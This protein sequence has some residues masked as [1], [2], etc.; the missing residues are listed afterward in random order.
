MYDSQRDAAIRQVSDKEEFIIVECPRDAMQGLKE[1]IDTKRKI[2]Y[3]NSLL[4]VNFHTLDFGSFVSPKAIPQMRDTAE[5]LKGLDL[6]N[7]KTKLLVIVANE[8]GGEQACQYPQISYL[9]Y[10]F[11]VSEEFQKRNTNKSIDESLKLVEELY[12]MSKSVG[13]E[14][15]VY[16]SMGFGNPYGEEWSPEIV[17]KWSKVLADMG[18]R[19]L[20][21]SDTV[22]MATVDSIRHIFE[23]LIPSLPH[24]TFGA[25]LHTLPYQ[26]FEKIDAAYKAGCR[27]FDGAIRGFGGCPMAKDE[28]TGNMPTEKLISYML[29]EQLPNSLNLLAF[30]SAYNEALKIFN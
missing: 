20:S 21:V 12:K 14:L 15:V 26:W 1:F 23:L 7:T 28:L 25:H 4:K 11:S 10:P 9:G 6:S 22:G 16:L 5:V 19:T 17:L 30:E 13:K 2:T 8:R 18:I 27:R 24:V 29:S 3:L